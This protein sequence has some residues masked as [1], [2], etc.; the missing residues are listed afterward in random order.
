MPYHDDRGGTPEP[1]GVNDD[2]GMSRA[3]SSAPGGAIDEDSRPDSSAAG[4]VQDA[5]KAEEANTNAQSDQES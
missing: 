5:G 2:P 3:G 4:S 1:A